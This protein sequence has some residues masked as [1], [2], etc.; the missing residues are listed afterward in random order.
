MM[1]KPANSTDKPSPSDTPTFRPN[2]NGG[3]S[4][5]HHSDR[6]YHAQ[7]PHTGNIADKHEKEEQP[8]YP[9]KNPPR[10]KGM[11]KGEVQP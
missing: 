4:K 5:V 8:V 2:D 6:Q 7:Q 3:K 10:E 9:V 1:S 11:E